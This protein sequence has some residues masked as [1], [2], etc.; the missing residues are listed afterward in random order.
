MSVLEDFLKQEEEML[1]SSNKVRKMVVWALFDSGNGCYKRVAETYRQNEIDLYA[2]GLDKENKNSHFINLNLASYSFDK[3]DNPIFNELDKLPKPDLIIAS[4][5]C[6]SWSTA[7]SM[8]EGNAC[9]RRERVQENVEGDI[10]TPFVVRDF[11]EYDEVQYYPYN[12]LITRINGELCIFNTIQ[13][14]QRYNPTCWV[15]E[16]PAFGRIWEYAQ[17]VL[18]FN[19]PFENL[20]YYSDYG[21][22]I[23]KP[24]RFSS[25]IELGLRKEGNASKISFN[26]TSGYNF[27]SNIP[28]K[29]IEEIY[30]VCLTIHKRKESKLEKVD[31]SF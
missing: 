6:E 2:I 8:Y 23:K 21:F 31:S 18:G 1:S 17:R 30:D 28:L 12:Q 3:R 11:N 13:I 19:F 7:S 16:N 5:P 9:W 20:T 29:L 26:Q 22:D 24:T 15:I 27:R 25:N 10:G 14:I 4:P